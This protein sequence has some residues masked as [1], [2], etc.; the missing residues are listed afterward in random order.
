MGALDELLAIPAIG[1]NVSMTTRGFIQSLEPLVS[2]NGHRF[3]ALS[4]LA[5]NMS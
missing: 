3:V 1:G 5:W 2:F 4:A